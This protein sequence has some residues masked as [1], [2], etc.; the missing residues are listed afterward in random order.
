MKQTTT[1]HHLKIALIGPDHSH[2]LVKINTRLLKYAAWTAPLFTTM[3]VILFAYLTMIF[4][5]KSSSLK[6]EG[7]SQHQEIIQQNDSLKAQLTEQQEQLKNLEQ[8]LIIPAEQNSELNFFATTKGQKDLTSQSQLLLQ[9]LTFAVQDDNLEVK[10]E[11]QNQSGAQRITGYFFLVTY[12]G[13]HVQFYPSIE[14]TTTQYL[15]TQGESFNIGR[16]RNVILK[17]PLFRGVHHI[18]IRLIA[19]NKLG[20]LL[21]NK[22]FELN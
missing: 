16:F 20:D 18:K 1:D 22:I 11:L 3:L 12:D 8:K 19:F 2:N 15:F 7:S 4:Y 14:A 17:T 13:S 21:H 6:K 10:F 9:N 5:K